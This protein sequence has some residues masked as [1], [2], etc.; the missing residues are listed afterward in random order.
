MSLDNKKEWRTDT[1][2]SKDRSHRLYA[3]GRKADLKYTCVLVLVQNSTDR[4]LIN[5]RHRF[6][7]VLHA[8]R[9]RSGCQRGSGEGPPPGCRRVTCPCTLT[10]QTEGKGSLWGLLEGHKP[11][12]RGIH[13]HDLITSPKPHLKPSHWAFGFQ[14]PDLA[15][16]TNT[17]L[18]PLQCDSISE[19]FSNRKNSSTGGG[20]NHSCACFRGDRVWLR[21]G[22]RE[23]CGG[24]ERSVSGGCTGSRICPNLWTRTL[25]MCAFHCL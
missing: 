1:H 15:G 3:E 5:N 19:K 8:A 18:I 20:K 12:S 7:A 4:G 25:R 24:A 11:H 22:A 14:R 9:P 13:P 17:Q 6:L 16:V 21:E 23:G 2:N 10:W